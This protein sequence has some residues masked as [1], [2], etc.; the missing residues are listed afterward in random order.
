MGRAIAKML[1]RVATNGVAPALRSAFHSSA[2]RCMAAPK[3]GGKAVQPQA[4]DFYTRGININKDGSDAIA[5][6]ED[7]EYPDWLLAKA[8]ESES[9]TLEELRK[10]GPDQL[11][12]DELKRFYKLVNRGSIKTKNQLT[13]L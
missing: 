3:K 5:I 4:A 7:S 10:A 13:L 2:V 8:S 6:G 12:V 11:S 1:R 9:S